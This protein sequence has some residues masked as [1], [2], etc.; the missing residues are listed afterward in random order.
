HTRFSRGWSSNVCS[1][2]L[3]YP[4]ARVVLK[5]DAD[6]AFVWED[7][8]AR[9]IPPAPGNLVDATGAGDSFAG[10]FLARYLRGDTAEVA[11]T[12]ANKIGRASCREGVREPG[13]A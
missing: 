6:G 11:A 13:E 10:A 7:G 4:G 12:F 1:S 2:D 3:I 8:S 9:H 5:L